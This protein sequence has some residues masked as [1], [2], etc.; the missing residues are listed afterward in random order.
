MAYEQEDLYENV[1]F[2]NSKIVYPPDMATS[3][4][5]SS[6]AAN[7]RLYLLD[8]LQETAKSTRPRQSV[9]DAFD[10][11]LQR[12]SIA[13]QNKPKPSE[14]LQLSQI[15]FTD[16][17]APPPLPK[18]NASFKV[19]QY[20][21][22]AIENG[23]VDF[24]LQQVHK[25]LAPLSLEPE[26]VTSEDDDEFP[27]CPSA[28]K[29]TTPKQKVKGLM[30]KVSSADWLT[31]L[32]RLS[33]NLPQSR[34]QDQI[35]AT[36]AQQQYKQAPTIGVGRAGMLSWCIAGS[37]RD[38]QNLWTE[39][40]NGIMCGYLGQKTESPVFVIYLDRLISIGLTTGAE[41]SLSFE[42]ITAKD[43]SKFILAVNT[44]KER[45]KWME[46]IL[47][48]AYNDMFF[49]DLRRCYTRSGRIFI[50]DG[51]TGE[52]Q[53]AWLLIQFTL[54]KLWIKKTVG[55]IICEDLRK[56]HSVSQLSDGGGC[57]HA[58]QPGSPLIIH[59]PDHT[60]YIQSDLRVET[61]TWFQL[62]RSVALQSGADLAD[63]QMTADDVP[64]LIEC[65]IKF[66]ETYGM[67]TEG[68]YRRSGVQ[69]KI[70]RLLVSLRFDAWNVH[71][72]N[73]E[74]TEHDVANVL[75]RFLRTLPEPLLTNELYSQ[76]IEGLSKDSHERQ[77]DHFKKLIGELPH[78]NRQT[79]RK[80]LGHLHAVQN[81]CEKNL[82]SV[83]NLAALWG[84]NLM[85]VESARDHTSN[86]RW[87]SMK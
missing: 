27:A 26:S 58:M 42:L 77:L 72:S 30:N 54:K 13:T 23:R 79:L 66:I 50:K 25:A 73:E 43:K 29:N 35:D 1:L 4:P 40:K 67:L 55:N 68:I 39:L 8:S 38:P 82:M 44:A 48:S 62:S 81:K 7:S 56:V 47:E 31:G 75:K 10:P 65:C 57:P 76:W 80:L 74:Y 83:S 64:V 49:S 19:H 87:A 84:P 41:D 53:I 2:R 6:A 3:M 63:H 28:P 69:S 9:L 11:V 86:F 16:L 33:S 32:K 78:V 71:I 21:S 12:K 18:R 59:W 70:N 60:C 51:V 37:K 45:F 14:L 20:D 5:P 61:E 36:L 17:T 52:W 85:T 46:W 15:D 34:D 24:E 22:V